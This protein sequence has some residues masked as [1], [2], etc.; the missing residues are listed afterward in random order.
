MTMDTLKLWV[1]LNLKTHFYIFKN[2]LFCKQKSRRDKGHEG[3]QVKK[4]PLWKKNNNTKQNKAKWK[5]NNPP[6]PKNRAKL[7]WSHK[8][9]RSHHRAYTGLDQVPRIYAI[10][11][12]L[13]LLQNAGMCWRSGSL[14]LVLAL[15]ALLFFCSL[16]LSIFDMIA[17]VLSYYS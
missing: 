16:G 15:R 6:S 4:G 8:D 14:I 2:L 1:H 17:F 11:F 3:H 7:I 12:S 5:P 9:W 10:T 13:V